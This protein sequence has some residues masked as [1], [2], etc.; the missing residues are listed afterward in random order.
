MIERGLRATEVV[1]KST[2]ATIATESMRRHPE[3]WEDRQE[4][5]R[6]LITAVSLEMEILRDS[7]RKPWL[8]TIKDEAQRIKAIWV[9]SGPGTYLEPVSNS[10]GDQIYR[11]EAMSWAHGMDHQRLERSAWLMRKTVELISGQDFSE[12]GKTPKDPVRIAELKAAIAEIGPYLI[13]N[14]VPAQNEV[15]NSVLDQST[16]I[17]PKERF[18]IPLG[19]IER[20]V[21]Q[22]KNFALPPGVEWQS[23]D[24]MVVDTSDCHFSRLLRMMEHFRPSPF[25]QTAIVQAFPTPTT[26]AG[27]KTYAAMEMQGTMD[28]IARGMA[29]QKPYPCRT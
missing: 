3:F 20:T 5:L 15:A 1:S 17:V 2:E 8:P 27:R 14:G 23:D 13:Y 10:P 18:F 19:Q 4:K 16:V 21:D 12:S 25:D 9:L 28:Y 22:V 6:Q 7:A 11:N 29:S 24:I 26:E